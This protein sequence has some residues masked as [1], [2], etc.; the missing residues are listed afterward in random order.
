MLRHCD[1][2]HAG[3]AHSSMLLQVVGMGPWGWLGERGDDV[4]TIW[5]PGLRV[6]ALPGH[7]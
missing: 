2:Q 1:W 3:H 5:R 7:L 6:A 4:V